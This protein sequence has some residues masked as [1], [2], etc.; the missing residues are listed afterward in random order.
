M[1]SP[2]T[3]RR[4]LAL[5]LVA[6]LPGAAASGRSHAHDVMY[7]NSLAHYHSGQ[8]RQALEGFMELLIEDA[9]Y[10]DAQRYL[11]L[12]GQAILEEETKQREQ[13]R[14]R[15]ISSIASLQSDVKTW[16]KDLAARKAAWQ[17]RLRQA[18]ALAENPKDL[19][20]ALTFYKDALAAFPVYSPLRGDFLTTQARFHEQLSAGLRIRG[21]GLSEI[22]DSETR[23]GLETLRRQEENIKRLLNLSAE[24]RAQFRR[25][26]YPASA[27]LWNQL[28]RE[29][30]R[31]LEAL[32]YL[33]RIRERTES[34]PEYVP[35]LRPRAPP[36]AKAEPDPEPRRMAARPQVSE[37]YYKGLLA[38]ST[39][40]IDA[41]IA[42]W[43]ECLR[44]EPGHFKA[45]FALARALR[46]Q[47]AP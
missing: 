1:I 8:H 29:I 26:R 21:D 25:R 46:E 15:L 35:P 43:Q 17:K 32:Y 27:D 18:L 33:Q 5:A 38:Y 24:A 47:G 11:S 30:P 12:T 41:A 20:D 42:H 10:P 3:L 36:P 40:D 19:R 14:R 4:R 7:H 34:T 13:E 39:G 16:R 31:H 37:L 45:S 2:A 44:I 9:S 22:V 23:Q 28:L 6:L